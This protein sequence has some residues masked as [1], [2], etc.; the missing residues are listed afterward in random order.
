MVIISTQNARS[1]N[2]SFYIL[3][4]HIIQNVNKVNEYIFLHFI[5]P[6]YTKSVYMKPIYICA[7]LSTYYTFH[8]FWELVMHQ[9]D[10]LTATLPVK[11]LGGRRRQT[12][13][14]HPA[15]HILKIVSPGVGEKGHLC[16]R[17]ITHMIDNILMTY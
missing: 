5:Y 10:F 15:H 3:S 11:T 6:H 4:I 14:Q 13:A 16:N 7:L 2:I 12:P 8:Y 9:A 17:K 1:T